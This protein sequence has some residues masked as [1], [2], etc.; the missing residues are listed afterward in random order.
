MRTK[1]PFTRIV[2]PFCALA[3]INTSRGGI[4]YHGQ[5]DIDIRYVGQQAENR[6]R[7]ADTAQVITQSSFSEPPQS[8][9]RENIMRSTFTRKEFAL[10]FACALALGVFSETALAQA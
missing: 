5:G 3:N 8:S 2:R 10:A 4:P 1:A 7:T 6:G 9:H